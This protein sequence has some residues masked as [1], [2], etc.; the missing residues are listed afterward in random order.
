MRLSIIT[1]NLNN[2]TGLQKTVIS[3]LS[4]EFTDFEY[5]IID[6]GSSDDSVE[7]IKR[8]ENKIAFWVSEKD[9]G[10]YN[11]MNKG[12]AKATGDYLLFLNSGDALVDS[13]VLEN[14]FSN[15][16]DRDFI[17]CDLNYWEGTKHIKTFKLPEKLT[18][19]FLAFGPGLQ[20]PSLFINRKV[21]NLLGHYNESF[22]I[23]SDWEFN[24]IAI[25]K[26][27]LTYQHIEITTTNFQTGGLSQVQ[28]E[29][30]ITERVNS[31]N[32]HFPLFMDD[33]LFLDK[34]HSRRL[35]L[36]FKKYILKNYTFLFF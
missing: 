34:L 1:I 32:N 5:L 11:A 25:A 18:F 10:I 36:I 12:I 33:Y 28:N 27:N 16:L 4:Q 2:S 35:F 24:L 3:V 8:H 20:H 19:R 31:L 17:Y 7:V 30:A 21:F 23:V 9:S 6:G 15:K 14:L 26:H 29:L 13:Q 22:K